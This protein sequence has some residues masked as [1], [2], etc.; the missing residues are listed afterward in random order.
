MRVTRV[1]VRERE[2]E[3]KLNA[4][5]RGETF[6]VFH[7]RYTDFIVNARDRMGKNRNELSAKREWQL[8]P[9]D[10]IKW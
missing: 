9:E 7:G 1:Q 4:D 2:S 8:R 10:G 6:V 5:G 3:S